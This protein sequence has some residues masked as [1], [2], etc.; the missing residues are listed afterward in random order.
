MR[1]LAK[2]RP[3]NYKVTSTGRPERFFTK[4]EQTHARTAR[5]FLKEAVEHV[6]L[7]NPKPC[8]KL[9]LNTC[10][11][12]NLRYLASCLWFIES[13]LA[14]ITSGAVLSSCVNDKRALRLVAPRHSRR[15]SGQRAAPR[16]QHIWK[17]HS[18]YEEPSAGRHQCPSP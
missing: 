6:L 1:L 12:K 16:V 4:L 3:C 18:C 5:N 9:L 2:N 13:L 11:L 8:V 14:I 10:L 15:K 17:V 7:A